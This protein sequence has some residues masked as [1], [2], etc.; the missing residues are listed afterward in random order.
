MASKN[1]I[2]K[3]WDK[4]KS[5][6]GK[7]PDVW[8]KDNHNNLI[9]KQSYGTKGEYGWELDH[10]N[11]TSKGGSDKPQNIQPLHWKENREKSD[12]YPYKKK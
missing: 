8:R 11:P 6:P 1:D 7:N 12:S 4:A 3:A 5:V 10:K 9:R 2:D